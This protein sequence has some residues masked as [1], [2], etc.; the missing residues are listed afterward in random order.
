M[1]KNCYLLIGDDNAAR[2]EKQESLIAA[3][4]PEN[5]KALGLT[6]LSAGEITEATISQMQVLPFFSTKQVF[7]ISDIDAINAKAVEI[8]SSYF[9]KTNAG[10]YVILEGKSFDG[11]SKVARVIKDNC[12]LLNFKMQKGGQDL[13]GRVS[14]A[15]ENAHRTYTPDAIQVLLERLGGNISFVDV[16]IEKLVLATQKG[17]MITA[18][19]VRDVVDSFLTYD[20]FDL[21]NAMSEKNNQKLLEV[22]RYLI[23][24]GTSPIELNGMLS[25]QVRRLFEAKRLVAKGA[26]APVIQKEL[27]INPYFYDRFMQQVKRFTKKELIAV[28]DELFAIDCAIK[29]GTQD[30]IQATELLFVRLCTNQLV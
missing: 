22:F 19:H 14:L 29:Q 20:V 27:R 30:P 3:W 7:V 24:Q 12:T 21:T 11:R 17:D 4:L 8:L 13:R 23:D 2:R 16:A 6:R 5:E 28:I 18:E 25:W 1:K 9:E 26:G 15:L 10:T